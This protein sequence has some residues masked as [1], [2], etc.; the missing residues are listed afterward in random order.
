M[1]ASRGK[2]RL[3]TLKRMFGI[4][5]VSLMIPVAALCLVSYS[6]PIGLTLSAD[7]QGQYLGVR[8]ENGSLWMLYTSAFPTVSSYTQLK[9]IEWWVVEA[10]VSS[11]PWMAVSRRVSNR[12]GMPFLTTSEGLLN[13]P[14]QREFR[15][16]AV[17][18]HASLL[19]LSALVGSGM[20][21]RPTLVRRIRRSKGK[22]ITCGYD[23]QGN[24]SSICPECGNPIE[25]SKS[26]VV[27][28]ADQASN[29]H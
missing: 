1:K 3:V 26:S 16:I 19:I 10:I 15:E 9:H 20:I 28:D 6:L 27:A 4:V 29:E 7:D 23:A 13:P 8:W 11:Q 5:F 24:P 17:R 2:R 12:T 25:R 14:Y 21:V 22:C 18:I